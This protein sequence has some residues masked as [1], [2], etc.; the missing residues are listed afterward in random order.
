MKQRILLLGGSGSIGLQTIELCSEFK[1][2]FSIVGLTL[3]NR[4]DLLEAQLINLPD[5]KEVGIKDERAAKVFSSKHPELEVSCGEDVNCRLVKKGNYDK[6]VNALVGSAGFL[7]SLETLR[8][9]KDLCLANKESLVIGGKFLKEE[10]SLGHGRLFA[11][12][13]EHVALAKLLKNANRDEINNLIITA[14][15]GSLRDIPVDKI[16]DVTL[17]D[18]LHHPTWQM[19]VRITV[20]SATMVNKGYEFIEASYLYDWPIEEIKV[21]INDESEVHSALEMKDNSYLFEVGPSD[22]R[23]PISYALNEGR[24]VSASYKSV[25]FDRQCSLNFRHFDETRYPLFSLVLDNFKKGGTAMAFLNAVDEVLINEFAK[26]KITYS[27]M[28]DSIQK[29]VEKNNF[30]IQDPRPEDIIRAD[31]E[32][33][34]IAFNYLKTF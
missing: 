16:K 30:F 27:Q 13:S 23:I 22:M 34:K 11:I 31:E 24:R 21:L 15:G 8:A 1:D 25:D 3:N 28:V 12:D 20:D 10:L 33:R 5:L 19:G 26:G 4:T 6:A 17:K 14:S 7:P 2:R 18:V 32:A 29:I 9:G